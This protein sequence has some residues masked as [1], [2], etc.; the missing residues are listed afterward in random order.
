MRALCFLA[1]TLNGAVARAEP[2]P[3][4]DAGAVE[5]CLHALR[6]DP[7]LES[8]FSQLIRLYRKAGKTDDLAAD[9]RRAVAG[10]GWSDAGP[11]LLARVLFHESRTDEAYQCVKDA[12]NAHSKSVDLWDLK[13]R[14][15]ATL[16]RDGEALEA[17][18]RAAQLS[19]KGERYQRF[20]ERQAVVLLKLQRPDEARELLLASLKSSPAHSFLVKRIV[21]VFR[22]QRRLDDALEAVEIHLQAL[23]AKKLGLGE[24]QRTKMEIL[25]ESGKTQ[26]ARDLFQQVTRS[27]PPGAPRWREWLELLLALA[28]R[29]QAAPVVQE[30]LAD[31]SSASASPCWKIA[32]ARAYLLDSKTEEAEELLAPWTEARKAQKWIEEDA[33]AS[34]KARRAAELAQLFGRID[35]LESAAGW[36]VLAL[37]RSP[38]RNDLRWRLVELLGRLGDIEAQRRECRQILVTASESGEG[39]RARRSLYRSFVDEGARHFA[40]AQWREA[41][42]AFETSLEHCTGSNPQAVAA[43]WRALALSKLGEETADEA[44]PTPDE[45]PQSAFLQ[46]LPGLEVSARWLAETRGNPA[47]ADE[48]EE[49]SPGKYQT[50]WTFEPP[51]PENPVTALVANE[52]FVVCQFASG[53]LVC[54]DLGTGLPLWLSPSCA[55]PALPGHLAVAAGVVVQAAGRSLP[56]RALADGKEAWEKELDF[57]PS[58]LAAGSEMI[59]VAASDGRLCALAADDGRALWTAQP[60]PDASPTLVLPLQIRV[61]P[62]QVLLIHKGLLSFG[63]T[64]GHLLWKYAPPPSRPWGERIREVE[65]TEDAA[66]LHRNSGD[67]LR[68][69]LLWPIEPVVQESPTVA[70]SSEHRP[71]PGPCTK[72][73]VR[74]RDRSWLIQREDNGSISANASVEPKK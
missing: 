23:D 11:A 3:A 4:L 45:V 52:Q 43:V 25:V 50:V 1:L 26:E 63:S 60:G 56:A 59:V 64:D 65:L 34:D 14:I 67:R 32:L 21:Q 44:W 12:L 10:A 58:A 61:L 22:Q 46:P 15:A 51:N 48:A 30:F 13:A 53:S 39:V 29:P 28:R 42:R 9:V 73:L 37:L 68:L 7:L 31:R 72:V 24:A 16:S 49:E 47:R 38:E 19:R 69:G 71:A 41:A 8:P 40:G 54:L 66:V 5:R 35:Q 2:P 62:R 18:Q 6:F 74:T 55:G 70:R 17:L 27:L 57:R 20:L 36:L 33:P